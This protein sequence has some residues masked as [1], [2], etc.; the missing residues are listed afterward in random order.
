MTPGQPSVSGDTAQAS[1]TADALRRPRN[2][3]RTVP[4]AAPPP[5]PHWSGSVLLAGQ[6]YA[7]IEHFGQRYRLQQTAAGKLLLTK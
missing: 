2:A 4:A 1:E 6:R 5:A 3:R 7:T